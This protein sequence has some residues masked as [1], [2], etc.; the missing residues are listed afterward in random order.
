[1]TEKAAFDELGKALVETRT[2]TD[3]AALAQY[4]L[5]GGAAPEGVIFINDAD[6]LMAAVKW[7]RENSRPLVP[8]SSSAPHQQAA[9]LLP[10]GR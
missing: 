10:D 7:A 2:S 8:A 3:A 4:A 1:M 9:A 6:T 5:P